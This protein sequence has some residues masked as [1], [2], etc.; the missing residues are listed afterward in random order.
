VAWDDLKR[1]VAVTGEV[2]RGISRGIV[3]NN[4]DGRRAIYADCRGTPRGTPDRRRSSLCGNRRGAFAGTRLR[5]RLPGG[6]ELRWLENLLVVATTPFTH[7]GVVA[8][9]S[10]RFR[11][12]CRVRTASPPTAQPQNRPNCGRFSPAMTILADIGTFRGI[13]MRRRHT[14]SGPTML[15]PVE[16]IA[17][18]SFLKYVPERVPIS[19]RIPIAVVHYPCG[20]T[21]GSSPGRLW[22]LREVLPT[23]RGN[24]ARGVRARHKYARRSP[25]R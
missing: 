2:P 17:T 11:S 4:R 1:R 10:R 7:T 18:L 14:V 13:L 19:T 15:E 20:T 24:S 12:C 3:S 8:S 25:P 6:L 22:N 9:G 21:A 5:C 23:W 16:V